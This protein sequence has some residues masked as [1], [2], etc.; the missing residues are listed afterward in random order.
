M[1]KDKA[2]KTIEEVIT[3]QAMIFKKRSTIFQSSFAIQQ[4]G[5]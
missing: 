1:E 3:I 4:Y 5:V 2:L